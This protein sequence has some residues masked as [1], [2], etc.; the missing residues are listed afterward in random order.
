MIIPKI[1]IKISLLLIQKKIKL[2]IASIS[3]ITNYLK[4][5]FIKHEKQS[6]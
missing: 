3:I 6:N 4:N 5:K 2:S 1:E